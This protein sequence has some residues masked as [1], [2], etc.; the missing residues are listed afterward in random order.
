MHIIEPEQV[1]ISSGRLSRVDVFL[2]SYVDQNKLAGFIAMAARR[3][4]LFYF[5]RFGMMDK[6]ANKPMAD[7]TMFRIYS[8]TKPIASVALM[9]LY[10]EGCFQLND[11]VSKFIPGF[12]DM[13]VHEETAKG[14]V[15][16]DR[17]IKVHDLLTHTS[18]LAYGLIGDPPVDSLYLE[19]GVLSPDNSLKE[20]MDILVTLPLSFQ[21]GSS[22]Q[23][24]IATDVIAYLVEVISGM[25]FDVFL[26]LYWA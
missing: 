1:G 17:E 26:G 15:D 8:M 19:A 16:L 10:E 6:E 14:L 18:G 2:Q 7:D 12:K 20:M 3:G 22:W 25:T 13:K 23:Y 4:E 24:S 11:P 21:P 9:M 5:N